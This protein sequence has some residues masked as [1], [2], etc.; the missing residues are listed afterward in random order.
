MGRENRWELYER[1][2]L[3]RRTKTCIERQTDWLSLSFSLFRFY[4]IFFYFSFVAELKRL[5]AAAEDEEPWLASVEKE[6]RQNWETL[7]ERS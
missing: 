3:R 2:C 1:E 4:F 5:R 7:R 6:E